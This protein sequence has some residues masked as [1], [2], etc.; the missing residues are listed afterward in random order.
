[1]KDL[2][3]VTQSFLF[4]HLEILRDKLPSCSW[5]HCS[6]YGAAEKEACFST[7]GLIKLA[8]ILAMIGVAIGI[9]NALFGS[10]D[11]YTLTSSKSDSEGNSEHCDYVIG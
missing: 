7:E 10:K 1:M 3:N 9:A 6:P 8:Q 4:H 11:R 2:K 5:C